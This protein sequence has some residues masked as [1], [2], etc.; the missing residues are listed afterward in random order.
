MKPCNDGAA[1]HWIIEPPDGRR[2]LPGKCV[3]CG[4]VR[5]F[6]ATNDDDSARWH[7]HIPGLGRSEADRPY[8]N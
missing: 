7:P 2:F 8:Y 3:N 1:H 6:L 4:D 5:L